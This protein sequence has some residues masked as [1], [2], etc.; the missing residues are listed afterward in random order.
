MSR[1]IEG[2]AQP[3]EAIAVDQQLGFVYYSD[4]TVGI[5][6]YAADPDGADA[7]NQC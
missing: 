4:E 2:A 5:R 6:K 7:A 1:C 3:L